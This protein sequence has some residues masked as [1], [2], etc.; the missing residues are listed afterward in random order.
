MIMKHP[1]RTLLSALVLAAACS[2]DQIVGVGGGDQVIVV[3]V[4]HEIQISLPNTGVGAFMNPPD[5]TSNLLSFLGEQFLPSTSQGP[6][7]KFLFMANVAGT[8]VVTFKRVLGDSVLS[9]TVD[10]VI[11]HGTG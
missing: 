5:M 3:P 6:T 9:T 1:R 8:T 11:V 4:G 2:S 10:T 7:E